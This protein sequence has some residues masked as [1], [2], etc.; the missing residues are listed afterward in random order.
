MADLKSKAADGS[1]LE[2]HIV[3]D[4]PVVFIEVLPMWTSSQSVERAPTARKP[5]CVF[6]GSLAHAQEADLIESRDTK[7]RGF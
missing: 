2:V 6:T 7:T 5:D 4:S 3:S 1:T